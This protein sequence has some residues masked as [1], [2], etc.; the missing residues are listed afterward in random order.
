MRVRVLEKLTASD[1]EHVREVLEA[2]AVHDGHP[3]LSEH[4]RMELER[5]PSGDTRYVLAWEDG[6]DHAVGYAHLSGTGPDRGVW[7]VEIVVHPQHRGVGFELALAEAALAQVAETGGGRVTLWAFDATDTH[8]ALAHRLGLRRS[9]DLLQM[10]RPLP[11]PD[12]PQWPAGTSVRSFRPGDEH[13]WLEVNGRAFEGHPEQGRWDLDTLR[14]R[15][16]EPWFDPDGFLVAVD[17]GG[18]AGFCWTKVHEAERLGEIYVIAVDP[19][20]GGRGLGKA[21][22]LAG[23]HSLAGRGLPGVMLYVDARNTPAVAMYRRLGFDVHHTDRAYVTD[24]GS[25]DGR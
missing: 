19:D 22:V 2:S 6:H 10:R 7:G 1:L 21:L 13:E 17:D 5:G 11:H 23:V 14:S 15:M 16:R 18:M 24:V 4:K 9:R 8:E 3:P 25:A 20:R 12:R